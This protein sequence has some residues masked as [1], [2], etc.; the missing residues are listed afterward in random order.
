MNLVLRIILWGILL[1][2]SFRVGATPNQVVNSYIQSITTAVN[3]A[4]H[5]P[6]IEMN[7]DETGTVTVSFDCTDNVVSSLK[8]ERSSRIRAFDK[9]ALSAVKSAK[10]PAVPSD[11]MH[12]TV[13]V[14]AEVRIP[15]GV[16]K[17]D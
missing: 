8:I 4:V 3:I 5:R 9:A 1:G 10:F 2:L 12:K 16:M 17:G 7:P 11:L 6:I 13:H 15:G 14:T